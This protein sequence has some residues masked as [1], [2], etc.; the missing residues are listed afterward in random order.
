MPR[1]RHG[2]AADTVVWSAFAGWCYYNRVPSIS[3][4]TV[5]LTVW[6][7]RVEKEIPGQPSN[8]LT[9]QRTDSIAASAMFSS[10]R[11]LV[12][13]TSPSLSAKISDAIFT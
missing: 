4:E 6:G 12:W 11:Q 5:E 9:P 8:R 2:V 1:Y 7:C 13:P 3:N 10:S